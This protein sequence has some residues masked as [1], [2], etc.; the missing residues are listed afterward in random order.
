MSRRGY[1][2]SSFDRQSAGP[3]SQLCAQIVP[4]IEVAANIRIGIFNILGIL[5]SSLGKRAYKFMK[6]K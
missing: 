5:L 1:L 6:E 3:S 4:G 2:Y